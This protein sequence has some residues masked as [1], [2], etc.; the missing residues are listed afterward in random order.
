M[1][2]LIGFLIAVALLVGVAVWFAERPGDVTVHWLGWRIDTT[3]PVLLVA[4]LGLLAALAMAYRF[5]AGILR[6][7]GRLRG[8]RRGSRQRKGYLALTD[9]LAAVAAG[10]AKLARKQARRA[11]HLLHNPPLTRLLSAQAAQLGGDHDEARRHFEA[12]LDRPETAFLG[13]RGLLTQALKAGDRAAALDYARRAHALNAEADWLT[14]TLFDLQARADLWDE[15]QQT[16]ET[17][18]RRHV[19]A[20]DE[21]ARKRAVVL[22]ERA[23]RADEDGD[24]KTAVKLAREAHAADG[25]LVAPAILLARLLSAED[26]PRK[27]AAV[28]EQSWAAAPHPDLAR[29]Y[30]AL[31]TGEDALKRARHAARLVELAP[32]AA[33]GHATAGEAAL[34]AQLWGQARKHLEAAA[35]RRPSAPVYRLLA[36][37]EEEESGDA[38]AGRDWLAKA[39]EAPP[40]RLWVCRQ[41]GTAPEAWAAL[42]G[43]CGAFDAIAWSAP[44]YVPGPPGL[45]PPAEPA[46]TAGPTG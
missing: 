43:H 19:F 38:A 4:M 10:D 23:R 13:L 28:L 15:A 8:Y 35:A 45:M 11:D 42:C 9:G 39:A 24:R 41:C 16:L 17:A 14:A 18:A 20:P 32:D 36:R 6:A 5:V 33:E 21:A 46:G 26:K 29:A 12:M 27:A 22:H 1:A 44:L 7:P 30:M 31:W 2:R 40:G 37:V 25:S 3:V 34:A